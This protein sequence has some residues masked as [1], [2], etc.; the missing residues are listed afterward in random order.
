MQTD[1]PVFYVSPTG[2][3]GSFSE[4]DP[5][6]RFPMHA[7]NVAPPGST[8]L[9][10]PGTYPRI[11]VNGLRRA[12]SADHP[13]QCDFVRS[14]SV[15]RHRRREYHGP[16]NGNEGMRISNAS[17]L[18]IENLKFQ[19]CWKNI[20]DLDNCSYITVRGCDFR[21]GDDVVYAGGGIAP[22]LL[23]HNTWKQR[24][25]IWYEWSWADVHHSEVEDLRHYNGSLYDGV[26]GFG[27]TVIRHNQLSHVFNGIRCRV[28]KPRTWRPISKS[29]ATGMDYVR[30]N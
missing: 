26:H 6:Q 18:V 29:T 9:L 10:L 12:G 15:C 20:I 7:L 17:W 23:E 22:C 4:S 1:F 27:A 5:R 19:N 13:G 3:G 28:H 25:E 14:G 11:D 2:A 30:D 24:E 21:E 16:G 8:I